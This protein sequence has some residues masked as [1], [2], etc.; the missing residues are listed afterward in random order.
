MKRVSLTLMLI[1]TTGLS[2]SRCTR[3]FSVVPVQGLVR[4]LSVGEQRL[5]KS[6]ESFGLKLFQEIVRADKDKN[7]FI[8]PLSVAMA[9]AMTYNGAAG[10]TEEAMQATLG[11][12]GLNRQEINQSFQSLISLLTHLDPKVKFQIAN[13]IW[14]RQSFTVEPQFINWNKTYFD[15]IVSGLDFSDPNSPNV[16]NSWVN[17]N[18]NG[19]IPKIIDRID[20]LT[21]MFLINAI[22]FKGTWTYEFKKEQTVDDWF[23]SSNSARIPCKM[24]VQSNDFMYGESDNFQIIDLPYGDGKFSMTILLPKPNKSMDALIE[25]M[26]P[27]RLSDW[28]G[29]LGKNHGT[30][31]LPKFKLEWEAMLNDVLTDLGMGIA[32][33][34]EQADFTG[35][36]KDAK[37]MQ[38]HIQFVKHKTFVQVDEEGTEAAAVTVVGV[39]ITSVGPRSF[40][41]RVDRPF[42]FMIR[43]NHSQTVLF[44]GKVVRPDQA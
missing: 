27:N 10:S 28:L 22:Y 41:M 8:S 40:V 43:E 31:Y 42:V 29:L 3:D 39:G 17:D 37:R 9:L 21:M 36:N 44:I 26:N 34:P 12:A 16:I 15:A 6:G 32:F 5:V 13:S 24:M 18:T 2:A 1:L 14:H 35:I 38:L 33:S 11:Y 19:K 20:S 23:N 30:L 25:L 4:E 7:V